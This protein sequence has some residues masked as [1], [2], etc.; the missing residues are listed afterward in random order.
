MSS[1]SEYSTERKKPL[2]AG[3]LFYIAWLI[4][5]LGLFAIFGGFIIAGSVFQGPPLPLPEEKRM[6][7]IAT[8]FVVGG[9]VM[10]ITGP[11]V[12]YLIERHRS[13]IR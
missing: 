4:F 10:A 8:A 5:V 12:I 2:K 13:S 6:K 11:L 3:I 9:G 1:N 7:A